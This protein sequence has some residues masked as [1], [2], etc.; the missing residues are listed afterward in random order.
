MDNPFEPGDIVQ[1]FKYE[2]LTDMEKAMNMFLY[3]VIGTAVHSETGEE[4]MVYRSLFGSQEM[5]VRPL[6]MFLSEVDHE[7]YPEI[8]QQF[9]FELFESDEEDEE[10]EE[11]VPMG[12][13]AFPYGY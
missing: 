5:F 3:Q 8:V 4:M 7:K 9:R 6:S 12:W 2:T 11:P 1:H 10:D 13:E